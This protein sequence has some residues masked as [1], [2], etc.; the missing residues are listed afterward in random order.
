MMSKLLLTILMV[1]TL[2]AEQ[3]TLVKVVDGDTLKV[4]Y[5]NGT[6]TRVRLAGIDTPESYMSVK[7]KRDIKS[8]RVRDYIMIHLGLTAKDY[9]RSKYNVGDTIDVTY[10]T[11]GRYRRPVVYIPGLQEELVSQ[12]L[13]IVKSY[14][15]HDKV[16]VNKLALLET[17]AVKNK[18][19]MWHYLRHRC[20]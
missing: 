5:P 3:V 10:V 17:V 18:V 7:A 16:L 11:T 14:N 13:A 19:F 4:K 6:I 2:Q 1:L 12:G 9:L 20:Y 15:K 8:C